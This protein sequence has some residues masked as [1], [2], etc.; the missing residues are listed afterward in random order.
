MRR[1]G[2]EPR[3]REISGVLGN[4]RARIEAE[5]RR[6]DAASR[7][8]LEGISLL[9]LSRALRAPG[10]ED[11]PE[12]IDASMALIEERHGESISLADIAEEVGLHR[13]TVAAGFRR[14]L[15]RSVGQTISEIRLAHALKEIRSGGRPLAEVAL[16]CGYYD[17]S[18]MGRH[19]KRA[20]GSTPGQIRSRR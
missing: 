11:H 16:V 19:V 20:T 18:H 9:L 13:S 5:W 1:L 12:W 2:P 8:A 3:P 4:L 15:G 10:A 7:A 17:Q 14:Y 6:E